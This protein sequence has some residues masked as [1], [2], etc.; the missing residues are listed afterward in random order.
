MI[1]PMIGPMIGKLSRSSGGSVLWEGVLV[2]GLIILPSLI[3]AV[4]LGRAVQAQTL[5]HWIAFSYTRYRAL[6]VEESGARS[7]ALKEALTALP[8]GERSRWRRKIDFLSGHHHGG[9]WGSAQ[10][11]YQ[12][13]WAWMHPRLQMTRRC[14]FSS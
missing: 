8:Q 12:G 1:G 2:L 7:K 9:V 11:R 6:G 10:I 3:F 13:L 5:L 4:E 14:L